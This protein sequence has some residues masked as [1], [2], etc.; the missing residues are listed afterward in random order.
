MLTGKEKLFS[1]KRQEIIGI[2]SMI[3]FL[4]LV[5]NHALITK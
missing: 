2:M 5:L 1:N 3:S 4:T